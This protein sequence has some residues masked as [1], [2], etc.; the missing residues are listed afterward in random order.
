[1]R[2]LYRLAH[3]DATETATILN[4]FKTKEGD[5]T[6]YPPGNLLIITETGS[7]ITRMMR[8]LE[9]IDVGGAGEQLWV[10]P[11]HYTSAS[12]LATKLIDILDLKG[13]KGSAGGAPGAA[14]GKAGAASGG[15]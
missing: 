10:E 7:N 14:G 11:I 1:M 13:G 3:I 12:E 15:G 2:R 5:I 4:K 8:I 6:V 9:E